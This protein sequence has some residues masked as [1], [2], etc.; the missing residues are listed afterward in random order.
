M[1]RFFSRSRK[2]KHARVA[3]I[4]TAL[5]IV[6]TVLANAVVGTLASR[7]GWYTSLD[8]R[9]DYQISEQCFTLLDQAFADPTASTEPITFIF[10][11]TE[12]EIL[13][14][15]MM[16]YLY[17]TTTVL[18]G[19]YADRIDIQCYD[20]VLDPTKVKPYMTGT[21][22]LTG[23]E[24]E[25]NIQNTS[26]IVTC[27]DY[28]RV[29][30]MTEFF[31]YKDNDTSTVWAYNGERKLVTGVLHA[32][33][34]D[35]PIV[36][37]TDNH[38]EIYYDYEFLQLLDDAG[39][40][41]SYLDLQTEP[42][43]EGC[44]LIVSYNPN[45]DLV[46][47]EMSAVSEEAKLNEFLAKDGNSFLL[48]VESGTA[49]LPNFDSFLSEWGVS[50]NYFEDTEADRRYRYS[51]Q[52][53]AQS[54]TSD[55]C[56]VYGTAIGTGHS[57]QIMSGSDRAIFKD[58]TSLTVANGY[59]D[60]GDGSYTNASLDR[61][62]YRLYQS[63]ESASCWANGVQRDGGEKMLMSLTEQKS[64][65][66]SSYVGVVA[67]AKFVTEEF[68]QSAVYGNTDVMLRLLDGI[69]KEDLPQGL[70]IKPFHSLDI[71]TVTTAQILYWTLGLSLTPALLAV[72]VAAVVLIKRRRA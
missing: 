1:K 45:S 26:V 24:K 52:D 2:A 39:Y 34:T 60:N 12:K 64:A 48:F 13:K 59:V 16:A 44:K 69:G 6:V 9:G 23:E 63:S 65:N 18:E 30:S 22:P 67:S 46:T 42:I 28:Y 72:C 19:R 27:G 29:Y 31:S 33:N 51:V 55:G 15:S 10:C 14:D 36:C 56:T 54:L 41:I 47:D 50:C 71:S 62:L 58:A 53:A 70:R 40:I 3:V 4:L 49:D 37:M 32:L 20:V 11:N 35:K 61:T 21:N 38:G 43:P 7:Y 66:A 25:N 68:L 8:V 5:V 57:A 17:S